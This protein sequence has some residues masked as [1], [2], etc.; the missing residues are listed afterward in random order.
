MAAVVA[1]VLLLFGSVWLV[2]ILSLN[3]QIKVL[4]VSANQ[5]KE[6]AWL[7]AAMG[8]QLEVVEIFKAY[9]AAREKEKR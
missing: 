7:L 4:R 8:N 9:R 1:G 3:S 5:N 6:T 2:Q